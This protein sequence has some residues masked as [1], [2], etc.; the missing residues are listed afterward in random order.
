MENTVLPK[1]TIKQILR[2][3]YPG[4]VRYN[5]FDYEEGKHFI[6]AHCEANDYDELIQYLVKILK[7]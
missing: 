6:G 5:W 2:S 3:K 4:G 1:K 7:I